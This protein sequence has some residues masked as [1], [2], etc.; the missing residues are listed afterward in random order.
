MKLLIKHFFDK[1]TYTLTY[2]VY[3]SETKSAVIIDPVW[4]YDQ[5]SSKLT[6]ISVEQVLKFVDENNLKVFYVLETHAHADHVSGAQIIRK[7]I[8]GCQVAIGKNIIDVQKVFKKVFNF[9]E[10]FKTDGS[11]FDLLL[12]DEQVLKAGTLAIKVI[13]TPGHTPACT[14][15]LIGDALFVG[16]TIF[17]PDSGT[18]RCDFPAG[19]ADTLYTSIHEKIYKLDDSIKIY[20]GHDY[21]PEGRDLKFETTIKEEKEKNI[22]LKEKTSRGEYVKF[23]T[24]R[25]K[26]L[27]APKLLLPSIQININGGQLFPA[28]ANGKNYLRIPI[29]F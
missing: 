4:N 14:S 3:D 16:D 27:S 7:K 23:R 19:S 10:S 26:T 21:Q 20:V 11:Q 6:T 17:M 28:E 25:D 5:A 29:S 13:A 2:V 12:A 15:F 18:G 9:D 22:Q 24:D 8:S 1:D